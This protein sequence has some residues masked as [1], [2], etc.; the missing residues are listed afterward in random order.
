MRGG[1]TLDSNGDIY[2]VVEEGRQQADNS[3]SMLKLCALHSDG[4]QKWAPPISILGPDIP[5]VGMASPAIAVDDTIYVGGDGIYAFS[6]DGIEMWHE[7]PDR[8]VMN[9]PRDNTDRQQ[10]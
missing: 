4:N 9:A 6:S 3:N 1:A 10:Y 2:F 7:I 5:D 8:K